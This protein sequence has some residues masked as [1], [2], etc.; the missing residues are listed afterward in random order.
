[1]DTKLW[2]KNSSST[3][4]P[5][6]G[7]FSRAYDKN[8]HMRHN[9]ERFYFFFATRSSHVD[10]MYVGLIECRFVTEWHKNSEKHV[11]NKMEVWD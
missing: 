8:A 11:N 5:N 10:W 1:M 9:Q 7:T 6:K 4:W 2:R 3:F